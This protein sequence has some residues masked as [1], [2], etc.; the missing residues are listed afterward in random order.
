MKQ[1]TFETMIGVMVLAVAMIFFIFAYKTSNYSNLDK[2]YHIVANF[3]NIDGILEGAD[4]KLSGIKIGSVHNIALDKDT[5]YAAVQLQINDNISIPK[6]S[7]A[8]VSTSGLLGGKYIKITPGASDDIIKENGKIRF[9][10]SAL[11]IEELIGK[12]M[13]SLTSK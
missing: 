4:V 1:G 7:S 3:Q 13:Y 6:D 5:Y 9:T 11:N 8:I 10:Q 12:L 2:G